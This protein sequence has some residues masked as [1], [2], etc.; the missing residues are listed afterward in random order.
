M[1][2]WISKLYK[3]PG[4]K[5]SLVKKSP[6]F[7]YSR[8]NKFIVHMEQEYNTLKQ[9]ASIDKRD[10]VLV[11]LVPVRYIEYLKQNEW[12]KT[13][14]ATDDKTLLISN[15]NGITDSCPY[16]SFVDLSYIKDRKSSNLCD[17][18]IYFENN[19]HDPYYLACN[20]WGL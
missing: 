20:R 9:H 11:V 15:L 3:T 17:I 6:T 7:N 2:K 13:K 18:L 14:L 16:F 12:V 8:I 5:S 4:T 1:F 10:Y 19:I